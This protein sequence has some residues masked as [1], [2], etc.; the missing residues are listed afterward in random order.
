M[1][2]STIADTLKNIF[3]KNKGLLYDYLLTI[4]NKET[5]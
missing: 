1:S 2:V 4:H 5:M 3:L